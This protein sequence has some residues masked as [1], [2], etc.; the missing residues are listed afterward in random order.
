MGNVFSV[1]LGSWKQNSRK[2]EVI[3]VRLLEWNSV[4]IQIPF[5]SSVISNIFSFY[6]AKL[7]A[8]ANHHGTSLSCESRVAKMQSLSSPPFPLGM[9]ELG[10]GVLV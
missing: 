7:P 10:Q 6:E 5:G 8:K 1:R 4:F 2:V 3:F 9:A